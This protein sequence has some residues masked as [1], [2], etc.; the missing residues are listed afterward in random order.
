GHAVAEQRGG[1]VVAVQPLAAPQL[2][3]GHR[4]KASQEPG[5]RFG[6]ALHIA[7]LAQKELILVADLD[8]QRRAPGAVRFIVLPGS[9]SRFFVDGEEE[10]AALALVWP[11]PED[12]QVAIQDR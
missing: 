8:D 4:I 9:L 6:L 5:F 1:V 7:R 12:G 2:L 3:A 10:I 11:A